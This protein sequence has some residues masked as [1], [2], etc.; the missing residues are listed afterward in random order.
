MHRF[1]SIIHTDIK[2]ENIVFSLKEQDKF[3]LLFDNVLNTNLVDLY[4]MEDKII[5][6]KK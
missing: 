5:L 3:D 4:E 6:N 2:P 1:C